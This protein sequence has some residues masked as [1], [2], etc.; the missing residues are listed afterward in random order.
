MGLQN[1]IYQKDTGYFEKEIFQKL[2]LIY[3]EQD[4]EK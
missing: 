2:S 3:I 1:V 4:Y